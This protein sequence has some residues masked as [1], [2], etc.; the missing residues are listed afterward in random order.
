MAHFPYSVQEEP[1]FVIY[2]IDTIL[3]VTGANLLHSFKEAMTTQA[4]PTVEGVDNVPSVQ[5]NEYEEEET[6]ESVLVGRI[7]P[8]PTIF[9]KCCVSSQGCLLLLYLKQH[10]KELYGFSDS[11]CHKYSPSEPTKAY[12]KT[13]SRKVGVVFNPEQVLRYVEEP[14]AVSS[15]EQL[16]RDYL[17]FKCLMMK[18]DPSEEDSD[19]SGNNGGRESPTGEAGQVVDLEGKR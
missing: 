11:K 3:S 19:D 15:H 12:D 8:D 6:L 17:E 4:K 1:L 7:P 10:L 18:L 16:V 14:D 2:H 13:V 9:E 5:E